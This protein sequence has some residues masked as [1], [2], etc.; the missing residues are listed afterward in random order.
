VARATNGFLTD[1]VAVIFD[2]QLG[3][4]G[5]RERDR[6]GRLVHPE[7]SMLDMLPHFNFAD[8]FHNG[9]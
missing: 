3:L 8:L 4:A 6:T 5:L 9:T 7:T 1:K 2:A